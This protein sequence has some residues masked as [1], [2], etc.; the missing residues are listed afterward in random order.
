VGLGAGSRQG[1]LPT[2][3]SGGPGAVPGAGVGS[4][5]GSG[6]G[7]GHAGSE[8]S[9][10]LA[11]AGGNSG[12]GSGTG[13]AGGATGGA[14]PGAGSGGVGTG[15]GHVSRL[16]DRKIPTLVRRVDPV[17]PVAA[18]VEG[19][20]GAVK[21]LVTVTKEGKVGPVRVARSSGDAR[22]DAAAVNAVKQWRYQPAVQDGIPREVDTY[23]TV[24]FSLE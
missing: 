16:A 1:D 5:T 4:G 23:A 7:A 18:Q 3:G 14:G 13:S 17:Y 24:T 15:T 22:L 11:P 6:P 19:V 9:G 8:G 2:S 21:L 20:Q 12:G 10:S